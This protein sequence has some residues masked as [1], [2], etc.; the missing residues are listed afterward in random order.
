MAGNDNFRLD[1]DQFRSIATELSAFSQEFAADVAEFTSGFS[2]D[3]DG[4]GDDEFAQAFMQNFTDP[5]GDAMQMLQGVAGLIES[6]GQRF[7][8]V[9]DAVNLTDTNF[10]EAID[11]VTNEVDP[12]EQG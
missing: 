4:I 12:K 5:S 9:A 6:I 1:P 8:T 10:K 7:T 11:K 2:A 3:E